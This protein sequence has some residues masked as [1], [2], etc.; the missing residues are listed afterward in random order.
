MHQR[1]FSVASP[2]S[3]RISEMIQKRMTICGSAQPCFS[4]W[5]WIGA[6]RKTRL[7][8][9]LEIGD[10]DDDADGFGHEEPA[11]DGQHDLVLGRHR[12]GAQ[13]AAQRERSGVAHEDGRRRRVVPQEAQ[14]AADQP[15]GEDQKLP[16]PGT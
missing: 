12:D 13:R 7:P 2:I 8:V 6:I 9:A 11:D 4:K 1:S 3:A 16:V 10:L 14:A 15:R 5:W